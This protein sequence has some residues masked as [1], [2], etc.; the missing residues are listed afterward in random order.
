MDYIGLADVARRYG[1]GA[2]QGCIKCTIQG[3]SWTET[4]LGKMIYSE[5]QMH[6]HQHIIKLRRHSEVREQQQKHDRM[7]AQ[8]V[9]MATTL[10]H[11]ARCGVKDSCAFSE[12]PYVDV[13]EDCLLDEMHT[14]ANNMAVSILFLV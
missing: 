5:H 4:G 3:T 6:Q 12:L 7:V 13:V 1:T 11:M 8:D 10:R 14:F 9:H 2:S